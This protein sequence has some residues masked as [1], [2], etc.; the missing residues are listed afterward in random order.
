MAATTS[1]LPR[2]CHSTAAVRLHATSTCAHIHDRVSLT[3]RNS[4][5]APAV[6]PPPPRAQRGWAH[7]RSSSSSSGA[8]GEGNN[9]ALQMF[10]PCPQ[11]TQRAAAIDRMYRG[12]PTTC[13]PRPRFK[14]DAETIVHDHVQQALRWIQRGLHQHEE[15]KV[16]QRTRMGGNL[17][18]TIVDTVVLKSAPILERQAPRHQPPV[19]TCDFTTSLI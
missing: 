7:H 11:Q 12:G 5:P 16:V 6:L 19:P 2:S 13:P 10:V 17:T 18:A 15:G 9:W 14:S 3:L 8:Q 4:W 1:A